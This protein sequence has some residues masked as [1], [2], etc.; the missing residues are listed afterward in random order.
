MKVF[1][2]L[3]PVRLIVLS[4]LIFCCSL[5]ANAQGDAKLLTGRVTDTQGQPLI[6]ASVLIKGD[7]NRGTY[8]GADGTFSLDV[9]PG[10]VLVFSYIGYKEQEIPY[11]GQASLNVTL[12]DSATDLDAVVVVGYGVQRKRDVTGSIASIKG[13]ELATTVA[14]ANPLQGLQGKV[15]GVEVVQ[16]SAPGGAP[17]IRVRGVSSFTNS[18]PCYV[19]DGLIMDNISFLNPNEVES[20]EV[21][22]DASATA[23]YGSRGANGVIIITTKQGRKNQPVQ[24]TVDANVSVSQMERYLDY[25]DAGQYLYLQNRRVMAQNAADGTSISL[26]YTQQQIDAAGRGTDWQREITQLAVTQNYNVNLVGGGEKTTYGLSSGYF[27]QEGVMKSSGYE[28]ANV[29]LSNT[30]DLTKWATIGSNISYIYERR[31]SQG[32]NLASALR[33]LPTAP[34]MDP[35]DPSKFFGPVDEIGKSGNPVANLYYNSDNYTNYYK[36]IANFFVKLEPVKNLVFQSSYTLNNSNS[37]GKSFLPKYEVNVDQRRTDNELSVNQSRTFNWLNENTLSYSFEKNKHAFSALVGI[38]FQKTTSQDQSQ[39]ILGMPD[40][41]W[42]NRDL[43]YTGLGQASTLTGTT[44][45]A[46]FTYLSYLARVNYNYDNKY[47]ITATVRTDGSS[48][49]PVN[50]RYGTFPAVGVGW[51]MHEENWLKNVGWLNQLKLRSSYG[52]VGSDAGIP[53]N[54]QTA[55]VNRVNGVFGRDPASVTTSEVLDM[56]IDY[57]LHWEEARQFDLGLDFRALNNRLT[58]EFDYYIKTTANILTNITLPGI[59]GST[60]SPLSN[61]AKARNTGIEFNIGWRENRGDFSYDLSLIGTTLKNKVVSVNQNLPP[62]ENGANVTKVGYPIGGFWG[63]EVLGIYQNKQIIEETA[64]IDGATP[65]DLW[66]KDQNGDGVIDKDDR[67][68]MGSYLP[69]VTLGLN[70]RFAYKGVDLEMDLYSSL[71]NKIYSTRR[72]TLG[73]S[74]Y[75]V[76]TDYLHSWVGEGSTNKTTRVLLDGP[77]TNNQY[78]QYYVENGSYFKIRNLTLGYTF[79]QRI[80][81]KM[82]MRNLRVYFSVHNLW[83]ATNATSYSPEI[84]GPPNGAG[85][86]SFDGTYPPSRMYSFGISIGI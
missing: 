29:K 53:N 85:I 17:Q 56:V 66:Y 31:N 45:G 79:P 59:S 84:S 21:L 5:A 82:K 22:K 77:G 60:Y 30:Y 23:I 47:L 7:I 2:F 42:K 70:M 25:A 73:V 28:R 34:V 62:L 69:K 86:D 71:G 15:A 19:V 10:D 6:G 61:I 51:A 48:R 12:Q 81:S 8:A 1:D 35:D 74:P 39:K 26:P 43:W 54:I 58:L 65:G 24:L 46:V 14:A 64:S 27:N 20:M 36:T 40:V 68:Y 13:S 11:T 67:I 4:A 78:S 3:K 37:E 63:Y 32:S 80:S 55:Y 44:G 76:T 72:Q 49:F 38:T 9:K 18:D 33:A 83:T 50:G 57:G 75:N 16:N 41:A 52:V